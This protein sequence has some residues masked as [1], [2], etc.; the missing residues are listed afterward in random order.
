M[1]FGRGEQ[2]PGN[3]AAAHARAR[4]ARMTANRGLRCAVCQVPSETPADAP[5]SF[6][7]SDL[8]QLQRQKSQMS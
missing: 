8:L 1:Y 5:D 2:V 4:E 6:A 3:L 7:I